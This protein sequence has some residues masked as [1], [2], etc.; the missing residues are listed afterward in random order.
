MQ[1]ATGKEAFIPTNKQRWEPEEGRETREGKTVYT[2]QFGDL[3]YKFGD[4]KYYQRDT[5]VEKQG[6][7]ETV[8]AF[9]ILEKGSDE[10][11]E[12]LKK[13]KVMDLCVT[14]RFNERCSVGRIL[15]GPQRKST[16]LTPTAYV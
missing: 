2:A 15:C 16:S 1:P 14:C 6:K 8:P 13:R 7:T 5:T 4:N 12:Y 9:D 3:N 11:T 10:H